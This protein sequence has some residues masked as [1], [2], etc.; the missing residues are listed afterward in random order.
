M[1]LMRST[2]LALL[3]AISTSALAE[4]ISL[5]CISE[6]EEDGEQ[7]TEARSFYIDVDKKEM[8]LSS[9]KREKWT[10][11]ED[12]RADTVSVTGTFFLGSRDIYTVYT[13][14]RV[15]LELNSTLYMFKEENKL[16][17]AKCGI[18]N[19]KIDTKF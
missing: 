4:P 19:F 11:L 17:P 8:L 2:S 9:D 16:T 18:S 15:N 10:V 7:K 14:N 13:I 6:F 12:F 3:A 1:R 5:Y